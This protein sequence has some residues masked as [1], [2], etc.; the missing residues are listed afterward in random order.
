MPKN[1]QRRLA[2]R[3][4]TH[5]IPDL[6]IRMGTG[7]Y[8]STGHTPKTARD[9]SLGG[10][11][12]TQ[13][14]NWAIMMGPERY[15]ST[16]H[17]PNTAGDATLGEKR[18]TRSPNLAKMKGPEIYNAIGQ[19]PTRYQTWPKGWVPGDMPQPVT[20]PKLPET[21]HSA[22]KQHPLNQRDWAKML[23]P[24]RYNSNVHTPNTAGDAS[25]GEKR[26]TRSPNLAKMKGP[27]R[28]NSIGQTPKT[29]GDASLG[30]QRSTRS[31]KMAKRMGPTLGG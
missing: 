5:S 26:P 9:A 16:V 8:A 6:A 11:T 7:R 29:A 10:Q 14:T 1:S 27:E 25:L 12:P 4:K 24:E 31:P 21:P 22:G 20:R 13:S 23:G 3:V 30:G 19:T 28:Y 17:T 15:N 18:P 2:R